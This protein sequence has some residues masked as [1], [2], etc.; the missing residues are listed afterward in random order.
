MDSAW[1]CWWNHKYLLG[2]IGVLRVPECCEIHGFYA[3]SINYE[4]IRI[5]NIFIISGQK[6]GFVEIQSGD[7]KK[8]QNIWKGIG[9]IRPGTSGTRRTRK[10]IILHKFWKISSFSHRFPAF[11]VES[12]D[13]LEN[14]DATL[15]R[16]LA[17]TYGLLILLT[18]SRHWGGLA[19]QI[20][21]K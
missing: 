9:F 16:N 2:N 15:P 4:E 18:S 13:F 10:T 21:E 20:H 5:Y 14:S 7:T 19:C 8:L 3:K 6:C 12:V 17:Q 11:A 1:T